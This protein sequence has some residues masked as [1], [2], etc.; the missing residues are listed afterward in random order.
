MDLVGRTLCA[1]RVAP[2]CA[3]AIPAGVIDLT[4]DD[5]VPETCDDDVVIV[6]VLPRAAERPARVLA[7]ARPSDVEVVGTTGENALED[8]P[9]PREHCVLHVFNVNNAVRHCPNCFCFVCE[10]RATSCKQWPRHCRATG[11]WKQW[12]D[13]RTLSKHFSR[14][15][16]DADVATDDS[17]KR[18]RR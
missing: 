6:A 4:D 14:F 17:A 5:V 3:D 16:A 12:R 15:S 10:D 8:Y 11:K 1:A 7:Q 18:Q 13:E 2:P 9:H